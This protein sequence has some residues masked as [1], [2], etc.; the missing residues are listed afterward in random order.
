MIDWLLALDRAANIALAP[1]RHGLLLA[2]SRFV[3]AMG[4]EATALPVA[5]IAS[6]LLAAGRRGGLVAPLWLTLLG[7]E[8]TTY[9]LKYLVDRPRPPPLAGLA[10]I[11]PSFPSAHATVAM[12]LYGFLGLAIAAGLPGRRT[13]VLA[14]AAAVILAIGATR[15]VLSLHYLS[16]VAA[17][18]AIGGAWLCVGSR[19]AVLRMAHR[20]AQRQRH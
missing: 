8:A 14:A 15:L 13:A 19:W 11:S 17:G 2:G 5:V 7:A 9:A 18:Y 10:A 3:T 16:D 12:A 4:T 6:G 1:L 20:M